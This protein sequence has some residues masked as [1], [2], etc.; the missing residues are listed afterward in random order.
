MAVDL[1][2]DGAAEILDGRQAHCSYGKHKIV[3][4]TLF[5]PFFQYR[6]PDSAWATD[7]CKCGFTRRAHEP[8]RKDVKGAMPGLAQ[9]PGFVARGPSDTDEYYCGCYGWE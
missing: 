1:A 4:S 9:C 3:D 7:H 2:D 8:D 6:G 5:L